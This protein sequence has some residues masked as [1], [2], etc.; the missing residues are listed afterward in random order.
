MNRMT[1]WSRITAGFCLLALGACD[2]PVTGGAGGP[3]VAPGETVRI[4]MLVPLG[5]GDTE[6]EALSQSLVNAARLAERDLQGV[7]LDL[8]VY[9]TGAA[10]SSAAE[11]ARTALDEGADVILGPLFSTATAQVAPVAA[12]ADRTVLTLS[13]NP[14]VAGGNV[15]VLGNTFENT[16]R[17]VVGYTASQGQRSL[18]VVHPQGAE[19]ALAATAVRAAATANGVQVVHTGAYPLSVQGITQSVPTIAQNLRGAG[20]DTVILTDGPTGGLTFV[21]ETLRGLGVRTGAVQFA[22]L[23]RWDVSA[24]A[25]AQPGLDGGWFAGPD[26]VLAAQFT[27]RYTANYGTAPH[28]LAGLAYDGVAAIGALAAEASAAGQRDAFSA[29]RLTQ[30]SGFAGV[31]GI[32]RFRNDGLNDRALAVFEVRDGVAV[33]IDPAPRSF[34]IGGT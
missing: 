19:G 32:F 20:A 1:L 27:N 31:M 21:A 12:A 28:P 25:M 18:S 3:S 7:E 8:T 6:R 24:Q 13:N 5:S 9:P 14:D 17:R 10:D 2:L 33:Q 22:G 30:A 26:R 29:A 15:Y 16:A 23:Q 11:I 4:A 34:G